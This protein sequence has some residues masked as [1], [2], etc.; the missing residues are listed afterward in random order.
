MKYSDRPISRP[1]DD[2]LGRSGFSLALARSIDQLLVAREG[3]VIGIL[4]KWGL[5]K[6]SVIELTLRYLTHLEMERASQ[7]TLWGDGEPVPQNLNQLEQ[8]AVVFDKIRDRVNAY[9]DLN[10]NFTATQRKYRLDLFQSWL[11]D[12]SDATRA[13]RY[14]RPQRRIDEKRRT[15]QV[16]FSPW[17]IAG[18]R[19]DL[20]GFC[21]SGGAQTK[22]MRYLHL[23]LEQ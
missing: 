10:Q 6:S 19:Q 9:D 3:F 4:G 17:L 16:R 15:I 11:R 2:A 22:R 23:Q 20:I 8:L 7:T 21:G 18:R 13:D 14:W 1:G 12:D 5:G